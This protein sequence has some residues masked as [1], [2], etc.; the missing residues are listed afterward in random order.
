MSA[1]DWDPT[2]FNFAQRLGLAEAQERIAVPVLRAFQVV[3]ACGRESPHVTRLEG[4]DWMDRHAM[5]CGQH[6]SLERVP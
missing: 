6:A 1:E 3:C 2:E 5:R 4:L